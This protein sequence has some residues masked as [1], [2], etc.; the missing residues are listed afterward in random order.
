MDGLINERFTLA[1]RPSGL[2]GGSDRTFERTPV[3]PLRA[4]A[5]LVIDVLYVSLDPAMRGRMNDATR[6]WRRC[7]SAR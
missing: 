7:D 1:S 5:A 4:G 6:P 3:P 2:P